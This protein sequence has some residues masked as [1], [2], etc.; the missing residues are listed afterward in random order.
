MRAH[1]FSTDSRGL[2]TDA[3][4][5]MF[6]ASSS[7]ATAMDEQ[8]LLDDLCRNAVIAGHHRLAWF[9]RVM[10]DGTHLVAPVAS[11]GEA[12]GYL[13]GIVVTWDDSPTGRGPGGTVV[14]TGK[15][16]TVHDASEGSGVIGDVD[17]RPWRKRAL[18][19]GL[20]SNT[21]IPVFVD[22]QVEGVLGVYSDAVGAFDQVA[23]SIH[24]ALCQQVGVGI[25]R[26]R[27]AKRIAEALG[28]TVR[29]LSATIEA[30]DPFTAG[31][32]SSVSVLSERIA[33]MLG[34]TDGEVEGIGVAAVVHDI[35][36]VAVPVELLLKPGAL[37]PEE[38]AM[39]QTHVTIGESLMGNITFPW[40]VARI[41]GQHHERLDGSGYPRG[42]D[43][44][45][46][47]TEA[48]IVMVA[49]VFDAMCADRPYRRH[50]DLSGTHEYLAANSGTLFDPEVVRAMAAISAEDLYR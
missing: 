4:R 10:H 27:A 46:I 17:Y 21:S 1:G 7:L 49:D 14:R 39:V 19:F 36:K 2:S 13:E 22:G 30:R 43:G 31:H 38:K 23:D 11:A 25:S 12:V 29:V 32:Q 5:A 48:K 41:I 45:D 8:Q 9:G 26:L 42:L 3:S 20:R 33:R 24:T 37:R 28:D 44:G 35:G 50:R 40:P 6:A 34:M 16:M 15:V 47:T 18:E